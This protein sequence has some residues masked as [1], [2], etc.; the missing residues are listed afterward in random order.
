MIPKA[1][2]ISQS[3]A[4]KDDISICLSAED[5]A[6]AKVVWRAALMAKPETV[7]IALDG[8]GRLIGSTIIIPNRSFTLP[9]DSH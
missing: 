9:I 4:M 3:S 1:P 7:R 6:P 5:R 2:Q 8:A